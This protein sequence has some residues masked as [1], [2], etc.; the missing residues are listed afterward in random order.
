MTILLN[1]FRKANKVFTDASLNRAYFR[2]AD[3]IRTEYKTNLSTHD[4]MEMLKKEGF[5]VTVRRITA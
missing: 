5:D 1:F 4:I 3:F 2:L